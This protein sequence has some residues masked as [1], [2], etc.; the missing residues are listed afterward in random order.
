MAR[1]E[2]LGTGGHPLSVP[3]NIR[4]NR[5]NIQRVER[6]DCRNWICSF[7][8]PDIRSPAKRIRQPV[9]PGEGPHRLVAEGSRQLCVDP[10]RQGGA[11][12]W[13][14]VAR[15]PLDSRLRSD[16]SGRLDSMDFWHP[17]CRLAVWKLLEFR[18]Q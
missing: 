3:L 1:R 7:S 5:A 17:D 6:M 16:R 11:G 18:S 9:R 2:H 12:G 8:P 15:G 10:Y 14:M 4:N 13:R